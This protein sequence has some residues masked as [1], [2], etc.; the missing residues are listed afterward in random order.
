V[1]EVVAVVSEQVPAGRRRLA[2]LLPASGVAVIGG[3]ARRAEAAAD[4]AGR[5]AIDQVGEVRKLVG[6]RRR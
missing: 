5:R 1:L 2:R 4:G 3:A 6:G